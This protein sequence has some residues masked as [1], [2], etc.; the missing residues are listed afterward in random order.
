MGTIPA[1][2]RTLLMSLV[3]GSIIAA[4]VDHLM[5]SKKE[6]KAD[7]INRPSPRPDGAELF[8]RIFGA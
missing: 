1:E 2:V 7:S 5:D 4:D 3:V 6:A 8:W